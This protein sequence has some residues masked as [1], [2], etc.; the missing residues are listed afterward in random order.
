M[1]QSVNT[2]TNNETK[3]VELSIEKTERIEECWWE[4]TKRHPFGSTAIFS[5]GPK[6]LVLELRE[7]VEKFIEESTSRIKEG[8]LYT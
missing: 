6:E 3:R 1:N 4:Q 8:I 5:I 2:W 7:I